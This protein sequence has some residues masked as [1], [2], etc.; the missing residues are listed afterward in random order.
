MS[1]SYKWISSTTTLKHI[2]QSGGKHNLNQQKHHDAD[3]QDTGFLKDVIECV[4]GLQNINK[5]YGCQNHIV[6][7]HQ[8][9]FW[10]KQISQRKENHAWN[11]TKQHDDDD[12]DTGFLKCLIECVGEHKKRQNK[13]SK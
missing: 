10:K 8:P 6:G 9:Q 13:L 5:T 4:G 2:S 7:F 12:Q 1:Q 11:Q 3:Y